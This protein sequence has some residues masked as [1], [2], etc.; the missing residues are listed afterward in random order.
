MQMVVKGIRAFTWSVKSR[1]LC[2]KGSHLGFQCAEVALQNDWIVEIWSWK[3]CLSQ[4]YLDLQSRYPDFL[5]IFSLDDFA[6][7]LVVPSA[8]S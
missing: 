3:K 5:K 4:R 8:G 2:P 1:L 7:E 6:L